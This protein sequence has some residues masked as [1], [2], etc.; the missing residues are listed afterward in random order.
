MNE[1]Q[2]DATNDFQPDRYYGRF[3][4]VIDYIDEHLD[5]DLSVERLSIVASFSKFHFHRQFTGLFGVGVYRYVQLRRMRRA[6]Y[7]L[8]FRDDQVVDIALANGYDTPESFARAFR[9]E[10][11]QSPSGFRAQPQWDPWH[12]IYQPLRESRIRAMK[13]TYRIEDVRMVDFNE[14][15]VAALEHRGDPRT[16]GE[17]VRR[18]I[19]WRK[20]QRLPPAVSATFNILYDNPADVDPQ[21]FRLDICAATTQAIRE[22][23]VGIVEKTIPA[24]RCAVLRVKGQEEMLE[25]AAR[26]LYLEWLPQSGEAPRDFP[27]FVQR[28]CFFPD[29]PEGEAI[30]DVF[31]PIG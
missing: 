30:L 1:A 22:N 15:R 29:V 9:R 5:G 7:Q 12:A 11:G 25:Q 2:S 13:N 4:K 8:A 17:S 10:I 18:F 21:D 20:Q 16:I 26:F 28:V 14:T 19:D 24:G 23:M 31:L 27:L 3:R 6:S